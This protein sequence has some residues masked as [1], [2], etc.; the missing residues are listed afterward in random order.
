MSNMNRCP[1]CG[2]PNPPNQPTCYSCRTPLAVTP[3]SSG[4]RNTTPPQNPQSNT[5]GL[6]QTVSGSTPIAIAT[7]TTGILKVF[8]DRIVIERQPGLGN[9]LLFG[10]KGNKEIQLRKISSIQYKLPGTITAGY[11][12]FAFDGGAETK[13]GLMDATRDE[14]SIMFNVQQRPAFDSAKALIERLMAEASQPQ[15]AP[16]RSPLDDLEHL[17]RLRDAGI[18]TEDEFQ[19][20]KRQILGI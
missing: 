8:Q 4:F 15:Q 19:T 14:N 11:I 7:G 13:M 18:I 1:K 16:T 12:Q 17:A 9:L 10:L 2:A 5:A 20:K 3:Q 6:Q